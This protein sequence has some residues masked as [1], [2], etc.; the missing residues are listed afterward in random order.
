MSG[1]HSAPSPAMLRMATSHRRG[2][3]KGVSSG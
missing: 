2:E 1:E 3:V